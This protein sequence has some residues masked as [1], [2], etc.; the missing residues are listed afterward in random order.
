MNLSLHIIRVNEIT[1]ASSA[2]EDMK[3][4]I[5]GDILFL[6][7]QAK[8]AE[9]T[10]DF[11]NT[12]YEQSGSLQPVAKKFNL[13]L[14]TTPWMNREDGAKFFQGNTKI[15]AAAFSAEAVKEKRNTEAVEVAPNNLASVR[16]VEYKAAAPRTFDEVKGGIEAL[17]KLEAAMKLASAQGEANL[18]KLNAG[19]E[20][21]LEWIPAV[22]VGRKN[23]E[24]LSDAVMNQVFK[25]NTSKLP[26]YAGFVDENKAYVIVQVSGVK[27]TLKDDVE[28]KNNAEME[29]QAAVAAEY[30]TAHGK[31]LKSKT[32]V[33]VD[34]KLLMGNND[35]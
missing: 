15:M 23:A 13:Q 29:Y 32:K 3:P 20:A 28:A 26:A 21:D 7:A 31:S 18:K 33:V 22:T 5:K 9:L 10:E 16:V 34:R 30:M 6:K 12:V 24:G 25:V 1:G 4:Q 19:Q 14:Q 8:Y 27:N 35:Q 17:L 11:S 2:Y